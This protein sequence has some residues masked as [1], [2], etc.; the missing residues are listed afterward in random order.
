MEGCRKDGVFEVNKQ[1]SAA[2][3]AQQ[4]V[5]ATPE[6]IASVIATMLTTMLR[7]SSAIAEARHITTAAGWAGVVADQHR[8]YTAVC[9]HVHANFGEDGLMKLDGFINALCEIHPEAYALA[10]EGGFKP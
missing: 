1:T 2:E 6:T 5:N 10:L 3:W 9:H 7:E 8:K 4:I